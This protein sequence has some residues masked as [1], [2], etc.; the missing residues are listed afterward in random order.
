MGI[1][2]KNRRFFISC[3]HFLTSKTFITQILLYRAKKLHASDFSSRKVDVLKSHAN[4]VPSSSNLSGYELQ[5]NLTAGSPLK[6]SYLG[7]ATV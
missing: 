4:S 5:T 2:E 3:S 7:K 6:W 1:W